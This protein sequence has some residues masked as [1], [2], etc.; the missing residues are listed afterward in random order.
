MNK[1]QLITDTIHKLECMEVYYKLNSLDQS[2]L[3]QL[4]TESIRDAWDLAKESE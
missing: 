1:T 4:L 2:G 3:K